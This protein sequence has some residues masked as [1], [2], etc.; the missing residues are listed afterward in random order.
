[1]DIRYGYKGWIFFPRWYVTYRGVE[2]FAG[3]TIGRN[4]AMRTAI[5]HAMLVKE[6]NA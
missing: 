3:R 6:I 5:K 4:R 1:M 2:F